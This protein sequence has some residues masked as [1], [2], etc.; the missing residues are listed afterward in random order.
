[1]SKVS[2]SLHLSPCGSLWEMS[3]HHFAQNW[4]PGANP[5][6]RACTYCTVRDNAPQNVV[7][8]VCANA[9]H[10]PVPRSLETRVAQL[11]AIAKQH[12]HDLSTHSGT[13]AQVYIDVSCK[14]ERYTKMPSVS[15]FF[16]HIKITPAR[17][18][19]SL[20]T[21]IPEVG[22]S[23]VE[24]VKPWFSGWLQSLS[25][26]VVS[27]KGIS[28]MMSASCEDG[29]IHTFPLSDLRSGIVLVDRHT[30]RS[31]QTDGVMYPAG[32]PMVPINVVGV[33]DIKGRS[34]TAGFTHDQV[35]A[36]T[37]TICAID[38]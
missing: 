1:M 3:H 23:E 36:A 9:P 2:D 17:L 14:P 31:L 11:E 18:S 21:R 13:H 27:G 30:Q 5:P 34:N 28:I 25:R 15:E 4:V 6:V 20:T 12:R 22:A 26:C 7:N 16:T 32:M 33:M 8:G 37:V 24:D 38:G 19:K 10:P 35:S 29:Q